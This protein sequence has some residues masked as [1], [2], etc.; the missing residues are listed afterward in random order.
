MLNELCR[1]SS[2]EWIYH[3]YIKSVFENVGPDFSF[4]ADSVNIGNFNVLMGQY[5]NSEQLRDVFASLPCLS[6]YILT[7]GGDNSEGSSLKLLCPTNAL[8]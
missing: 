8:Y 7:D 4:G 1:T 6:T 5:S 3:P 2:I